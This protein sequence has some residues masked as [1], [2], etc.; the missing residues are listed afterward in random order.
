MG[1]GEACDPNAGQEDR[2]PL[3]TGALCFVEFHA[4]PPSL[5]EHALSEQPR[6]REGRGR[7]GESWA[8]PLKWRAS[9]PMSAQAPDPIRE[10]SPL[11]TSDALAHR[12]KNRVHFFAS[13]GVPAKRGASDNWDHRHKAGDDVGGWNERVM[14]PSPRHGRPCAGHPDLL[15]RRAPPYRDH[16]DKPGDDVVMDWTS[17]VM[18]GWWIGRAIKTGSRTVRRSKA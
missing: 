10:V 14:I 7:A 17:P 18:T 1:Q 2:K 8:F 4:V 5:A 13:N 11:F 12:A 15:G 6:V 9:G 3:R 16:R